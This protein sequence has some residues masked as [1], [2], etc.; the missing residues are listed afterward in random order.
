MQDEVADFRDR[1]MRAEAEIANVRSRAKRDVDDARQYAVQKFATDIVE[2]VDNLHRGLASLPPPEADEPHLL[3]S[4]RTGFE[5]IERNFLT[6]LERHGVRREDVAIGA[7]F[8]PER[9]Q[10]MS[11]QDATTTAPGAILHVLSSGWA[12][13]GRLL[14]PAMVIVAKARP[15][16][17]DTAH[18]MS[19]A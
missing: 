7:I 14:R 4:L 18:R 16:S 12:L 10:A 17:A 11:E 3:S 15:A 19:S 1:W 9:Q 5:G 13:N 8:D 2:G 6:L